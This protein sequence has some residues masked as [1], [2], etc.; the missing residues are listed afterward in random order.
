MF[1]LFGRSELYAKIPL[2]NQISELRGD[3]VRYHMPNETPRFLLGLPSQISETIDVMFFPSERDARNRLYRTYVQGS[4]PPA[5]HFGPF[6]VDALCGATRQEWELSRIPGLLARRA[7][8]ALHK[9]DVGRA[10]EELQLTESSTKYRI[11]W[12]VESMDKGWV[13]IDNIVSALERDSM[14]N[15]GASVVDAA[16]KLRTFHDCGVAYQLLSLGGA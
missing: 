15:E 4:H 7:L 11:K 10:L 2:W 6:V 9:G 3:G 16:Y 13:G 8:I 12:L 14:I 1:N 5:S